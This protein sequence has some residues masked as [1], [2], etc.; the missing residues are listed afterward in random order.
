M[1]KEGLQNLGVISLSSKEQQ[2]LL[3]VSKGFTNKAIALNLSMSQRTIEHYLTQPPK[4]T[5]GWFKNRSIN[6]SERIWLVTT[7]N[8]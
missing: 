3:E 6:E 8:N 2:V 4:K 7:T 5:R 1:T